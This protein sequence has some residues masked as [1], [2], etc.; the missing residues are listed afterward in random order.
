[1]LFYRDIFGSVQRRVLALYSA[2]ELPLVVAITTLAVEAGYVKGE[3]RGQP[4]R[5]GD[6]LDPDLP[7]CRPA[8]A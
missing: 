6:A 8:P 4:G 3:H 5:R 1:V 7:L 2:T